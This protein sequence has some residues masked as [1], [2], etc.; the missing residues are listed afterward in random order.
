[1]TNGRGGG[2]RGVEST[3]KQ[4]EKVV[5]DNKIIERRRRRRSVAALWNGRLITS[6]RGSIIMSF[7]IDYYW[8]RRSEKVDLN[9]IGANVRGFLKNHQKKCLFENKKRQKNQ[10]IQPVKSMREK[11]CEWK[12]WL[13]IKVRKY[14]RE[15]NFTKDSNERRWYQET[16]QNVH[17]E[18]KVLVC[19]SRRGRW[20][21]S[22]EDLK[23]E[24]EKDSWILF[25]LET[26][27]WCEDLFC[28]K[29]WSRNFWRDSWDK[30]QNW[31]YL[32][33]ISIQHKYRHTHYTHGSI[34]TY[35]C[36]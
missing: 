14:R 28:R 21:S 20:R 7:K 23:T 31:L 5:D 1:M 16:K 9:E 33:S 13:K 2:G 29:F 22:R 24:K 26:R 3:K 11:Q 4:K 32:E 6:K 18:L 36:I 8:W 35:T 25:R 10:C 15:A 34:H 27:I 19:N 12:E 17:V 30:S